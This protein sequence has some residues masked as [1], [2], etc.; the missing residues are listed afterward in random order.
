M[1]SIRCGAA[2]ALWCFGAALV[3]AALAPAA[4]AS[5]D[6]PVPEKPAAA[7]AGE[8][9]HDADDL[10]KQLS[11]PVAAL[12]SVPIQSNFDFRIGEEEHGVKYLETPD[13]DGPEWGIRFALVLIFPRPPK[14]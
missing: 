7:A 6:E 12:V 11:N 5:P 8:K 10:A 4:R 3:A 2:L 14:R 9:G 13:H 1:R